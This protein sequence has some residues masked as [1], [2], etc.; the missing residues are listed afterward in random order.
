MI[1]R[2]VKKDQVRVR[3]KQTVKA[4]PGKTLVRAFPAAALKKAMKRRSGAQETHE[5]VLKHATKHKHASLM[6]KKKMLLVMFA[7]LTPRRLHS[8]S[9]MSGKCLSAVPGTEEALPPEIQKQWAVAITK[10]PKAKHAV[11]N[12]Y[13]PKD[14]S[15]KFKM[16]FTTSHTEKFK[17]LFDYHCF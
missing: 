16:A 7:N 8:N 11:V 2:S 6:V 4:M 9:A 12:A 14:C 10:G 1:K 15:Y 3:D 13:V 17:K 5:K